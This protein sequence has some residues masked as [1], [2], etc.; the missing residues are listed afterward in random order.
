MRGHIVNKQY[1]V[2]II[3]PKQDS[4][5]L[6]ADLAQFA[7]KYRRVMDSGYCACITD[8]A[9]GLLAFQGHETIAELG[10]PV[11]PEQVM[12][13]L[14][15]FH[16]KAN[17][18]DLLTKA[19]A[20]GFKYL[21]VVSGDGS[22]RL[23]KLQPADVGAGGTA[24]VTSVE[25]LAYIRKNY[26]SFELGVAFNP[27]E[28]AEHEFEKMERKIKA[29]ASFII[30]Q[31]VIERNA[32]V[33]ELLERYLETPVIVEAW[34]TKK[35][36]LLSDVVGYAIPQNAAYSP[37]ETLKLL[38]RMYPDCGFYL[39]LLG[40]KT[41]YHLVEKI[42]KSFGKPLK[43]VVCVKQVPAAGDAKIDPET[44]RIVREGLKSILNP[45]DLYAVEEA[46]KLRER[47]GGEV[48]ALS[49][50][51]E[52]AA[53]SLRE[54]IAIGADK[55]VLLSG[56]AFG[57]SDTWATS[58]ALA[59]A[60]DTIGGVDLVLCGKQAV[61]GDTA[62]VGPGIAAHLGW[63][64]ATYVTAIPFAGTDG[65]TVKR[66]NEDGW[67]VCEMKFP[68]VLTVVKGINNPRVP[69]LENALAS[70]QAEIPVWNPSD[71]GA[72]L[73]KIGLNPSPTR[74]VR[75]APPPPRGGET[76]VIK[77][78]PSECARGLIDELRK[79]AAL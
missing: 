74:V 51:P 28:P 34:M 16:S 65:L 55:A 43:I 38:H 44:K 54:A 64:Q 75:T 68:A 15:T 11:Y 63:M 30:T 56:R 31:P 9:M 49:M 46:V 60:I 22:D 17:L 20:M 77:G 78:A 59:R 10:L 33:D 47:F 79:R 18:D 37:I 14:N 23:P 50:G 8:N 4:E 57:G 7:E 58:Y 67:D 6:E 35:L 29:G 27:Y 70:R 1:H 39:S 13:H 73:D 48:T 66:M 69:S 5:N 45:F 26:P 76:R 25:L 12:L 53:F 19:V 3:P 21:L 41:Q 52:K 71:I 2:E 32:V 62:Q 40:F 24:A 42:W 72:E 61:D 36:F